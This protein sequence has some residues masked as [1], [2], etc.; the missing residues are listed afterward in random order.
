[1]IGLGLN[2]WRTAL[3]GV[4]ANP[5]NQPEHYDT[6][7]TD[8]IEAGLYSNA[9]TSD[10]ISTGN[11][12][13][14]G[15]TFGVDG[16]DS[17]PAKAISWAVSSG[18]QTALAAGGRVRFDIDTAVIQRSTTLAA[19]KYLVSKGS[20]WVAK[21]NSGD[22]Q[23]RFPDD[24]VTGAGRLPVSGAL[25][26]ARVTLKCL[27]SNAAYQWLSIDDL[28]FKSGASTPPASSEYAYLYAGGL[29][30]SADTFPAG[31]YISDYSVSTDA[32][33]YTA[34]SRWGS[35]LHLGDSFTAGGSPDA[36][37]FT[38]VTAPWHPGYGFDG[39]D[40]PLTSG[41]WTWDSGLICEF[42][43]RMTKGGYLTEN[44]Y[45]AAKNGAK[46]ADALTKAQSYFAG[47]T[48]ALVVVMIGTNDIAASTAEATFRTNL[49]AIVDECV[50][51]GALGI[52]FATPT[53]L[54]NNPTYQTAG[55]DTQTAMVRD[56]ILEMPAYHNKCRVVDTFTLMGG[57]SFDS[58]D[59]QSGD[60]HPNETGST[61]LGRFIGDGV[62]GVLPYLP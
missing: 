40:T 6:D 39:T 3:G 19:S 26:P 2:L 48:A 20:G 16:M 18:N 22:L 35:V 21:L 14:G 9:A 17:A 5:A 52:V 8:I 27:W 15:Q 56:V 4:G 33:E 42:Y 43:R 23:L 49:R 11:T 62:V 57:H 30:A 37:L 59:F 51:G 10:G 34:H 32:Y 31:Y 54:R 60:I 12:N 28:I 38:Y 29:T 50:A 55:Y 61:R 46:A 41:S 45:N 58:G 24:A 7:T 25:K 47:D 1:M 44:N 53:S 13:G 36:D